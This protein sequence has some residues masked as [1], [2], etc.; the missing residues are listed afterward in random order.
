MLHC[1]IL[2]KIQKI[3]NGNNCS[4]DKRLSQ[5]WLFLSLNYELYG[6]TF[7]TNAQ[8]IQEIHTIFER[9]LKEFETTIKNVSKEWKHV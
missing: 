7:E 8:V 6:E 2:H 5:L 3:G 1:K 4:V 9:I